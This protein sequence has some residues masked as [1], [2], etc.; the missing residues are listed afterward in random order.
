MKKKISSTFIQQVINSTSN[1]TEVTMT[2]KID[3]QIKPPYY[4]H[5]INEIKMIRKELK[6]KYKARGQEALWKPRWRM[7][8]SVF[9][10]TILSLVHR[11]EKEYDFF[12]SLINISP[13]AGWLEISAQCIRLFAGLDADDREAF[14]SKLRKVYYRK[15]ATLEKKPCYGDCCHYRERRRI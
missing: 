2:P 1:N 10:F 15:A 13:C 4:T 14:K 3:R 11:E 8:C 12:C 6:E 5:I 7:L 9:K